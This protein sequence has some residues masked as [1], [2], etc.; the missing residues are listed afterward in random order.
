MKKTVLILT[1]LAT[2]FSCKK[3]SEESNEEE[4]ITTITLNFREVSG[5]GTATAIFKDIDGNGGN[6]PTLFQTVTLQPNKT[7]DL[8]ATFTDES[9][10]PAADITSEIVSEG[11]DHQIFYEVSGVNL[12]ISN[13]NLDNAN[14]PLGTTARWA[15]GAVGTG[16]VKMTLKHKPGIKAV[17]DT[18]AKGETDIEIIWPTTIR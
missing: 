3:S 7:Y 11:V 10:S 15:T 18:V 2:L 12:T 13:L 4:L 14:L 6:P 9:K 16:T 8:S 5:S 1:L 17:G